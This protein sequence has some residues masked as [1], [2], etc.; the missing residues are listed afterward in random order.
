M[1][2]DIPTVRKTISLPADWLEAL[3]AKARSDGW[4]F[5]AWLCSCGVA[6]LSKQ[7]RAKLS[8]RK[9]GRPAAK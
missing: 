9:R 7:E 1:K 5:S 3:E 2:N 6:Q 4:E 8:D